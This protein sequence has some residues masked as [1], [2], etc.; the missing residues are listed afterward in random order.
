MRCL[1]AAEPA[2][3]LELKPV[4]I[5]LL[6]FVCVVVPL[7]ALLACEGDLVSGTRLSHESG[8]PYVVCLKMQKK[9]SLAGE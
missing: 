7:L 4:R 8:P 3:L 9:K 1:L 2:K 6:V 5:V